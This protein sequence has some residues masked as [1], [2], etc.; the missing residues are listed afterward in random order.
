MP[1]SRYELFLDAYNTPRALTGSLRTDSMSA[2][3]T[4]LAEVISVNS[5]DAATAPLRKQ[6]SSQVFLSEALTPNTRCWSL[7]ENMLN[8]SSQHAQCRLCR[9]LHFYVRLRKRCAY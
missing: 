4:S 3:P 1:P 8:G 5:S 2:L 7:S 6:G 9:G